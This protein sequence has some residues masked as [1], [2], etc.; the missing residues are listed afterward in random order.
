[1]VRRT[2]ED[3]FFVGFSANQGSAA[4]W[5]EVG[6][7]RP[8]ADQSGRSSS[9][10]GPGLTVNQVWNWANAT[11]AKASSFGGARGSRRSLGWAP[12]KAASL[13][14]TKKPAA[15][16][17]QTQLLG[18]TLM[19]R[20][21]VNLGLLLDRRTACRRPAA[22]RSA[23]LRQVK[24]ADLAARNGYPAPFGILPHRLRESPRQPQAVRRQGCRRN[25]PRHVR[26]QLGGRPAAVG[27][28]ARLHNG[29]ATQN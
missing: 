18:L 7:W 21:F 17:S 1:M 22:C 15:R 20:V 13:S 14:R 10:A 3:R 23:W 12:F 6:R 26:G 11:S 4:H 8:W 2:S 19:R 9:T 16:S 5:L 28:F 24:L 25:L 27:C 29:V